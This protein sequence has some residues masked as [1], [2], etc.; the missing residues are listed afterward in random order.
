MNLTDL[1]DELDLRTDDVRADVPSV[2]AGVAG[3]VRATK[4]R[5]TATGVAALCAVVAI[6]GTTVSSGWD[7]SAPPAPAVSRPVATVG[8]DGMPSRIVPKAPGDVVKGGLR[9]RAMV[10]DDRLAVG[11]I[12]DA[13]QGQATLLW[14]P[15]TTH[16]SINAECHLPGVDDATA[17]RT[18]LRLSLGGAEG[19]FGSGC[20]SRLPADRDLPTEGSVPGE[21]GQ[22]W[23]ELTVGQA[24]S[25]R[26][27]LVDGTTG[28][29][30]QVEGALITAA[31]YEL[32]AQTP[33]TD[34]SG[35]TVAVVPEVREHQGYRYLLEGVVTRPAAKG[36]LPQVR[37]PAGKPFLLTWGSAGQDAADPNRGV[38]YLEG[39]A[40]TSGIE[41]GGWS[42]TA[43]PARA[44]GTATLRL[45]GPRPAAGTDFIAVYVPAE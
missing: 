7:R 1:R 37:T 16:V 2:S 5:R 40:E 25:L 18:Q 35:K 36:P 4:R 9:Y 23:S 32:G 14:E 34:A 29:P 21:A 15:T 13:G 43:Q 41:G 27:Q 12:G 24:A 28:K 38:L 10:A 19:F 33:V 22:G 42:T 26:V 8:A 20:D 30:T 17:K 31:V 11:F 6:A 45:D 39:L 44:A 3:K